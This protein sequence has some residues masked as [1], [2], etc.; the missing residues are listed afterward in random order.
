[1]TMPV[2][3]NLHIQSVM[4]LPLLKQGNHGWVWGSESSSNPWDWGITNKSDKGGHYIVLIDYSILGTRIQ[5]DIDAEKLNLLSMLKDGY[6][7]VSL[8]GEREKEVAAYLIENGYAVLKDGMLKSEVVTLTY[9]QGEE[10]LS[11]LRGA[12]NFYWD[13]VKR[14]QNE[15]EKIMMIYIPKHLHEQIGTIAYAR[16]TSGM[17]SAVMKEMH[18]QGYITIP[19]G[20]E[21]NSFGCYIRA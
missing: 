18:T 19:E 5:M 4:A 2:A 9:D 10:I 11:V 16:T 3:S 17:M 7:E 14:I 1:M 6:L 15:I 21:R 13:C 12:L 8:L 20:R